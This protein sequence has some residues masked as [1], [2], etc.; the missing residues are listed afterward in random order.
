MAREQIL[1]GLYEQI[2]RQIDRE[3]KLYHDRFV[4]LIVY[5]SA[6][7]GTAISQLDV[8]SDQI[9]TL[10]FIKFSACLIAA[11]IANFVIH[12][13][14]SYGRRQLAYLKLEYQKIDA[15]APGMFIRP[16]AEDHKIH[17]GSY[18]SAPMFLNYMWALGIVS[19]GLYYY[20]AVK[21]HHG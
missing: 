9:D 2:S 15:E 7:A 17:T 3:D 12:D 8:I 20:L 16:F 21:A 5:N 1:A 13:M 11:I 10:K 18:V 6:L 19:L 4:A 14:V